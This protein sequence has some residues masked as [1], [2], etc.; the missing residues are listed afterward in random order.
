MKSKN[1]GWGGLGG[2]NGGGGGG[3]GEGVWIPRKEDSL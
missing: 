2:V 3:G 1:C